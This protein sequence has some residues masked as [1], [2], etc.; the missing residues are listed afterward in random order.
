MACPFCDP[1]SLDKRLFYCQ[2]PDPVYYSYFGFLAYPCHARGHVI[3]AALPRSKKC[4]RQPETKI[5]YRLGSALSEVMNV[6]KRH[7]GAKEILLSSLRGDLKHFHIHLVPLYKKEES[8]WRKVTDY[9]NGHL[10]EFLGSLERRGDHK[11]LT[12]KANGITV[13]QQRQNFENDPK[14]IA[15]VKKL[16]KLMRYK[17][18]HNNAFNPDA[19]QSCFG[20]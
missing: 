11:A 6:I 12:L 8:E 19:G 16:R 2:E 15:D 7:Y 10:M 14:A 9:E 1:S 17:G 13:P 18:M 5:L 3:L 4:P 20:F